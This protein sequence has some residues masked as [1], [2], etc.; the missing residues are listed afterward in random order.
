MLDVADFEAL[1]WGQRDFA[2]WGP[3]GWGPTC[4]GTLISDRLVLTAAHCVAF[5]R[6]AANAAL[7]QDEFGVGFRNVFIMDGFQPPGWQF[8]RKYFGFRFGFSFGLIL[9]L[10]NG[11]RSQFDSV[12]CLNYPFLTFLL[13]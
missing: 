2:G 7:I 13:G 9:G 10:K 5:P 8:N 3:S 4:S 11:L 12:T 6:S 1:D